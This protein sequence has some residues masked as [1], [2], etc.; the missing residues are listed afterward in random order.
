ETRERDG[1]ELLARLLH[2]VA[3]MRL[4]RVESQLGHAVDALRAVRESEEPHDELLT[5]RLEQRAVRT[6][7]RVTHPVAARL[8]LA[9]GDLH[10]ARVVDQHADVISL[11]HRRGEQQQH[12]HRERRAEGKTSLRELR[13]PVLEEKRKNSFKPMGH[14]YTTTRSPSWLRHFETRNRHARFPIRP[15]TTFS[16]Q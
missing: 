12:D 13:W 10:A 2:R 3:E 1:V 11:R 15:V 14:D 7:E 5:Q 16:L 6:A 9:I 4:A 8:V